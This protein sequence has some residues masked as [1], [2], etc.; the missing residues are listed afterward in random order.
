M[1]LAECG[2]LTV[3]ADADVERFRRDLDAALA[4]LS[5]EQQHTNLK[6]LLKR[7][8]ERREAAI[9]ALRRL[10]DP[11]EIAGFGNATEPHNNTP[12]MRARLAMARRAVE[13]DA[14]I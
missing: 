12:E 3:G 14:L 2:R 7:E 5:P 9:A 1:A 10:A 13:Q 4:P 11:T 8:T 6:R